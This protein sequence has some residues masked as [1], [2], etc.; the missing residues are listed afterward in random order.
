MKRIKKLASL[1]L[2]LAMA[3]TL[4]VPAMAADT[5]TIT[6]KNDD[7]GHTYEAYQIFAGELHGDVLTN[8]VWGSGITADGQS[9]LQEQAGVDS[10]AGVAD[11]LDEETDA[12]TFA[13]GVSAY[14]ADTP[15]KTSDAGNG[16]YTISGLGAGYYLIKDKDNSLDG[17]DTTYTEY[18]I[19]IVKNVDITPKDGEATVEKK[20]EDTNDSSKETTNWQDSADYDI[21][22]AVP[23]QIEA[24][25][26]ANVSSFTTYKVVFNDTMS[27]GLTY[28]NDAK[29]YVDGHEKSVGVVISASEEADGKTALTINVADVKALGAGNNS[30]VR[31][32]YTATLN[33]HAVLGKAGNPNTVNMQYSNNPNSSELGQTK[34]DT[35]IVFT[36]KVVINKVTENLE[37]LPGAEFLLEKVISG[38]SRVVIGSVVAED[39]ATFTFNGLDD[40][41]YILTETKTPAKFN[42]IEPIEFTI[43][44]THTIEG[45]EPTL[46]TLEGGDLLTGN[47]ETGVLQGN[48]INQS[49]ATLPET[50]GMGTTLFYVLGGV[51]V[52]GAGVVLVTK[53][54]MA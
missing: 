11:K 14:L 46:L 52:I 40:G 13:A 34:D 23:F 41:R 51:L 6:I 29:L 37:A 45:A 8:I 28:N 25:L 3:L 35:V 49:G 32:N 2:A 16:V 31:V 39:G 7:D 24:T 54:R 38:S 4:A 44:A 5:Y 10:A 22:D 26:P 9:A 43:S 36:Y 21:G 12:K 33:Q 19:K 50:G 1:V 20:V 42:S 27:A 47:V 53:K 30:K 48:V 17:K 18:M 15:T